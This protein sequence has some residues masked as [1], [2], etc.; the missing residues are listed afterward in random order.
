MPTARL[1]LHAYNKAE[2]TRIAELRAKRTGSKADSKAAAKN[3]A[4]LQAVNDA[5]YVYATWP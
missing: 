5:M 1:K 4:S 3:A 2:T